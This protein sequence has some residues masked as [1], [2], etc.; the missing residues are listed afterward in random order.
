MPSVSGSRYCFIW[1]WWQAN[2][3]A[4]V[5]EAEALQFDVET[6][7]EKFL[8]S[9]VSNKHRYIDVSQSL[10]RCHSSEFLPTITPSGK[11]LAI[12]PTTGDIR[13]VLGVERLACHG[14]DRHLLRS[15]YYKS[16]SDR[17]LC[18]L[19]G[20]MFAAPHVASV[21]ILTVAIFG[22]HF[23]QSACEVETIKRQARHFFPG[24]P[25]TLP[26]PPKEIPK[27]KSRAKIAACKKAA[28]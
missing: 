6:K 13:R 12:D 15:S 25:A 21:L 11:I 14:L 22:R 9:A 4:S 2:R 20:N 5:R 19:A 1:Q 8:A 24:K 7:R 28:T 17:K 23:P 18:D 27:A 16:L 26:E 10:G 3:K